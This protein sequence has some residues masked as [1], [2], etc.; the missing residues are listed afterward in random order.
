[1]RR[2]DAEEEAAVAT[3]AAEALFD[4]EAQAIREREQAGEETEAP[5]TDAEDKPAKAAKK[6]KDEA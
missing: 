3:A 2:T 1:M 5:A 6:K 4:P